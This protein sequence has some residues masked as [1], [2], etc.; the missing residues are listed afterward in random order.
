MTKTKT[1]TRIKTRKAPCEVCST[2]KLSKKSELYL[3][4]SGNTHLRQYLPAK[5]NTTIDSSR[6]KTR[7]TKQKIIIEENNNIINAKIY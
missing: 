1:K 3:L 7:K 2:R 5:P 4:K 6:S